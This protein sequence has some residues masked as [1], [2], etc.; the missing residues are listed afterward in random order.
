MRLEASK[1]F[2]QYNDMG[3]GVAMILMKARSIRIVLINGVSGLQASNS[4]RTRSAHGGTIGGSSCSPERREGM[5]AMGYRDDHDTQR[6]RD[7]YQP[8]M[9]HC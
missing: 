8:R 4:R 5:A 2:P 7:F 1:L 9:S 3:V 6:T